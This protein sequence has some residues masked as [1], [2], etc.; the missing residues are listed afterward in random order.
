MDRTVFH[1][2]RREK[3]IGRKWENCKLNEGEGEAEG[4]EGEGEG[5]NSD[6]ELSSEEIAQQAEATAEV[7]E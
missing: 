7:V 5:S 1:L 6:A 4:S 3:C 2:N